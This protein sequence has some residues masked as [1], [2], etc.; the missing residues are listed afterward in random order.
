MPSWLRAFGSYILFFAVVCA[1]YVYAFELPFL[2][3]VGHVIV[4]SFL[5]DLVIVVFWV[6]Y[7]LGLRQMM[8][9]AILGLGTIT[10]LFFYVFVLVFGSRMAWGDSISLAMLQHYLPKLNEFL[11]TLPYPQGVV[12]AL[13]ALL[14]LLPWLIVVALYKKTST[15]FK[16]LFKEIDGYLNGPKEMKWAMAIWLLIY[17]AAIPFMVK[18]A[19]D[20]REPLTY[21][22]KPVLGI[23]IQNDKLLEI[24]L[25]DEAERLNYNKNQVFDSLNVVLI[26]VDDL[27]KSHVPI[28]GYNR[29]VTPFLSGLYNAQALI[30]IDNVTSTCSETFCGL[31]SMLDS[32]KW[33]DIGVGN[34]ALQDLLKDMGYQV[35]FVL[36]NDHTLWYGLRNAYGKSIDFYHD[37][38]TTKQYYS[39][40]DEL[41]FEGLSLMPQKNKPAFFFFHLMSAHI[42]GPKKNQFLKYQPYKMDVKDFYSGNFDSTTFVNNYDNGIL[43]A[44]NYIERIFDWLDANGYLQNSLVV[45]TSDHG[46][47][48]GEHNKYGH[49]HALYEELLQVPLLIYDK[50]NPGFYKRRNFAT[51]ID[52]APTIVDRL[53]LR[54][55]STW[56]GNSLAN[57][58]VSPFTFHE[59][60]KQYATIY[61][62]EG[63]RYK[64]IKQKNG[65]KTEFYDLALDPLELINK[66]SVAHY[67]ALI[68]KMNKAASLAFS[69]YQ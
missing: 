2:A 59:T 4:V 10:A 1:V 49:G 46:E 16:A 45:I 47:A 20:Q 60:Q 25:K 18:W 69:D 51:H 17:F 52:F 50:G 55:P 43:Q 29:P 39:N 34:F 15:Y 31:M 54:I 53:G 36:S 8:F 48:F 9:S 14:L 40:D 6:L 62:I 30:K 11:A 27:R 37:G 24:R 57:V 12:Y 56:Q 63:R 65:G 66:A 21:L 32:K 13:L 44:D 42:F 58:E 64:L 28:Y 33:N 67:Q 22:I 23:N 35:N 68:L 38:K 61:N 7:R 19:R 41:I 5:L 26:V 3:I